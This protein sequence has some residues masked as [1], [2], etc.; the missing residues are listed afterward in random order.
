VTL[1]ANPVHGAPGAASSLPPAHQ[2]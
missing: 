2:K 1:P